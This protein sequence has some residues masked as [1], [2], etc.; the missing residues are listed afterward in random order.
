[1]GYYLDCSV[2]Y[3]FVVGTDL[4]V[5]PP[6]LR[7]RSFQMLNTVSPQHVRGVIRITSF[8]PENAAVSRGTDSVPRIFARRVNFVQSCRCTR[9]NKDAMKQRRRVSCFFDAMH[10]FLASPRHLP[11]HLST[12]PASLPPHRPQAQHICN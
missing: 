3:N 5:S 6:V 4:I 11:P 12:T 9:T 8:Q 7:L 2:S 10:V 1:M